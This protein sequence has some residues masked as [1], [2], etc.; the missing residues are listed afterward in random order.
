M[1]KPKILI[2]EDEEAI[3]EMIALNLHN[4]NFKPLRAINAEIA[5]QSLNTNK[6]DL[7]ILDWMLPGM[8]GIDFLKRIRLSNSSSKI[9]VIMLTAKDQENDKVLGLDYGA[10]DYLSKPFSPKE[11]IARIKAILR[12]NS[13]G[14]I[15]EKII[16]GRL[17]INVENY[18][19][20][21]K[22][23]LIKLGP[24]EFKLLHILSANNQRVMTRERIVEKIWSN[25]SEVD[26]RTVDVHIK[27][28]RATLRDYGITSSI[29]T[30]RGAG[31]KISEAKH[32]E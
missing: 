22:D 26:F 29:E 20:T 18:V 19:V 31:Y 14:L 27:R 28:L 1:N 3:L 7:I 32:F 5:E 12:R 15:N 10:D 11:L 8:S 21:Y 4:N 16:Y 9:P 2:V 24:T 17:I 25:E 23:N 6:P 13:P 30:I